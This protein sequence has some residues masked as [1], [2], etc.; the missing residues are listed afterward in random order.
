[1]ENKKFTCQWCKTTFNETEDYRGG[2]SCPNCDTY[3]PYSNQ[4]TYTSDKATNSTKGA[5]L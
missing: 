5:F 3:I 1:M 4:Q 2:A